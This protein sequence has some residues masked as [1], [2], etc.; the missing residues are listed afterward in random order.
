MSAAGTTGATAAAPDR[1]GLA[2][3]AGDLATVHALGWLV[4]GNAVGVLLATLLLLPELNGPLAPLTYGRWMP[5]HWNAQLYGWMALPLVGLL[6]RV[7]RPAGRDGSW[8]GLAVSVWSAALAVGCVSWLAGETTA[9]PFL[10][11]KGPVRWLLVASLALL[12]AVLA[13]GLVSDLLSD[14]LSDQARGWRAGRLG[15]AAL[16]LALL[17]VPAVMTHVT[18]PDTYPPVNPSSGGPTGGSLLASTLGIVALFLLAPH[19]LGLPGDRRRTA[20]VVTL[21]A[22]HAGLFLLLGA[23]DGGD[24]SHHEAVQ[25]AAVASLAIWPPVLAWYLR[26]F[27]WPAGTG[28]WLGALAGWGGFLVATAVTT[29][30]P[31]VLERWKFTNALV[32]HAHLAMAGLVTSFVVLVMLGNGGAAG[33]FRAARP[34]VLWHAACLAYVV[35]MLTLGALEGMDPGLVIRGGAAGTALYAVRLAAG[36]AML[37]ASVEWLAGAVGRLAGSVAPGEAGGAT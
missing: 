11:W 21:L 32:A 27:P 2:V 31:G 4:V 35:S 13:S 15:K 23:F 16:L 22:G 28:R 10:E 29:F 18:S 36:V 5:V 26:G 25:V 34:F 14:P 8:G 7:Y 37:A 24:H 19:L 20:A 1:E 12:A 33:V 9:K 6:L 17:P 30:L 3:D